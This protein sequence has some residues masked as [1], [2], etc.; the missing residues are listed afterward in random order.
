[1]GG[2]ANTMDFNVMDNV[3]DPKLILDIIDQVEQGQSNRTLGSGIP[4]E[5][6][7]EVDWESVITIIDDIVSGLIYI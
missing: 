4:E 6:V 3:E 7:S 1:V 5:G 2:R